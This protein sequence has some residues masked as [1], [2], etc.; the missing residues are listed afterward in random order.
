MK[1]NKV[2][3]PR[4][5]KDYMPLEAREL[6]E[7]KDK[8]IDYMGLWGYL[9]IQTPSFEFY[10]VLAQQAGDLIQKE[11]FKFFDSDGELLA[12]KP[13]MTTPIARM[14]CQK[15]S[16]NQMPLRFSYISEVFRQEP[17]R[18]GQ[19]R[20]YI[21]AG[22]ELIGK[23]G[24][25]ADA[26]V[27]CVC[28]D[29]LKKLGLK[30]F[31]INVGQV[32]AI[33]GLL[34]KINS[35]DAKIIRDALLNKNIAKIKEIESIIGGPKKIIKAINS[36]LNTTDEKSL[37]N[38]SSKDIPDKSKKGVKSLLKTLNLVKKYGY[39]ENINPDLSIVSNFEYYTGMVF[40][41]YAEGI[42]FLL[43][44]G[45]R[46]DDLLIKFG[47]NLSAAG[48]AIGLE[49][50]HIAIGE[51]KSCNKKEQKKVVLFADD[52]V[53]AF[54][55]ANELRKAGYKTAVLND[56]NTRQAKKYAQEYNFEKIVELK[57]GIFYEINLD[58]KRI[59]RFKL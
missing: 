59:G 25:L 33:E 18:R 2:L 4:G 9:L 53:K 3:L 51:K 27:L 48:F 52:D 13:D 30:D 29:T 20:Q 54:V 28:I 36:I 44:S 14:A 37:K 8:L 55:K 12:L 39:S 31:K 16:N 15:F 56:V 46:Y 34:E 23:G 38:F 43:G 42:G 47:K 40:E 50:L 57:K 7:I 6:K 58:G 1:K 41:I 5:L 22:I 10:E 19:Q 11:M 26:E 35:P 32:D 21:Q 45:G 24:N 17:P 49:R